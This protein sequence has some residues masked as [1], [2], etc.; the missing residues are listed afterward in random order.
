MKTEYFNLRGQTVKGVILTRDNY[1]EVA[2]WCDGGYY[3]SVDGDNIDRRVYIP[4]KNGIR[5]VHTGDAIVL[6]DGYYTN[7]PRGKD[8]RVRL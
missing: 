5:T 3:D 1:K 4:I 6:I 7:I 8:K 2:E